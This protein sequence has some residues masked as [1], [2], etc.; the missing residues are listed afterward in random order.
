TTDRCWA[1]ARS[2]QALKLSLKAL[3]TTLQTCMSLMCGLAL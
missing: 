2:K 1:I 3:P